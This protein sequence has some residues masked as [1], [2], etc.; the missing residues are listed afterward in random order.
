MVQI[1]CDR[2]ILGPHAQQWIQK[3]WVF[4][5]SLHVK[6]TLYSKFLFQTQI[7]TQNVVII[8]RWKAENE[9]YYIYFRR[10]WR[11]SLFDVEL[12]EE[13]MQGQITTRTNKTHDQNNK[14][15]RSTRPYAVE[16]L[17]DKTNELNFRLNLKKNRFEIL[18]DVSRRNKQW[19]VFKDAINKAAELQLEGE[20]AWNL[21]F[22]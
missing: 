13:L 20:D 14:K 18:Q 2:H 11:Y 16:R 1:G 5:I 17:K 6:Q 9:I 4:G 8:S 7:H 19:G 22:A 21:K 3:R 10:R 12:T 15:S